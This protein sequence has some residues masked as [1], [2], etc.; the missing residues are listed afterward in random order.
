MEDICKEMKIKFENTITGAGASLRIN[1]KTGK[2]TGFN[3]VGESIIDRICVKP[4]TFYKD[5]VDL[6]LNQSSDCVSSEWKLLRDTLSSKNILHK[7][8]IFCIGN[9]THVFIE[10]NRVPIVKWIGLYKII[11]DILKSFIN[12]GFNSDIEKSNIPI[13]DL[14]EFPALSISNNIEAVIEANTD[15]VI[16]A[17]TDSVIEASTDAVIEASTDAVI[18]PVTVLQTPIETPIPQTPISEKSFHNEF[19]GHTPVQYYYNLMIS[20]S[21]QHMTDCINIPEYKNSELFNI[22]KKDFTVAQNAYLQYM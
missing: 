20:I 10:I 7:E 16:E 11:S 13:P 17:S 1:K 3:I 22:R 15:A 18:E 9:I 21:M 14:S 2:V 12:T 19:Y 4:N 5:M 6:Q 8:N